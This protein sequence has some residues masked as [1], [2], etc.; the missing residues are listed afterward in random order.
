MNEAHNPVSSSLSIDDWAFQSQIIADFNGVSFRTPWDTVEQPSDPVAHPQQD[1]FGANNDWDGF[2]EP[3]SHTLPPPPPRQGRFA[4]A[5]H[6]EKRKHKKLVEQLLLEFVAHHHYVTAAVICG[7]E[8]W[9]RFTNDE[10][11]CAEQL[12]AELISE[13]GLPL[14]PDSQQACP[15]PRKYS[16][17]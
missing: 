16:F 15:A 11:D 9:A 12:I 13:L 7:R 10:K 17:I 8:Q 3:R 5:D 4:T 1:G 14:K 2:T 6:T